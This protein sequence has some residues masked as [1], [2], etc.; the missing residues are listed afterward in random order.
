MVY[1][2]SPWRPGAVLF[3]SWIP[4]ASLVSERRLVVLQVG[5]L[6]FLGPLAFQVRVLFGGTLVSSCSGG[7]RPVSFVS[8]GGVHCGACCVRVLG[9]SPGGLRLCLSR[10]HGTRNRGWSTTC[11]LVHGACLIS[12]SRCY[13]FFSSSCLVRLL[14]FQKSYTIFVLLGRPRRGRCR[15]P[16]DGTSGATPSTMPTLLRAEVVILGFCQ[17]GRPVGLRIVLQDRHGRIAY[18]PFSCGF[19]HAFRLV[20]HVASGRL[21]RWPPTRECRRRPYVGSETSVFAPPLRGASPFCWVSMVLPCSFWTIASIALETTMC[22]RC[23]RGLHHDVEIRCGVESGSCVGLTF[24]MSSTVSIVALMRCRI[25]KWKN[26]RHIFTYQDQKL[27]CF[28]ARGHDVTAEARTQENAKVCQCRR[29]P[30]QDLY[31]GKKKITAIAGQT[32]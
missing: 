17:A 16:T 20:R 24:G 19:W 3:L 27:S 2:L 8:S 26:T 1:R 30:D 7:G 31:S 22:G 4:G 14:L 9:V 12:F 11:V 10:T 21:F 32:F 23:D 5:P 28:V 29:G 25:R 18:S 15:I 6:L 13:A